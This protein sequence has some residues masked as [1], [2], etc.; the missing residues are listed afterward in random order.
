MHEYLY[1]IYKAS[2]NFVQKTN[3]KDEMLHLISL[4]YN[5]NLIT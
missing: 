1:Y 2:Y 5:Y 4:Q 3:L